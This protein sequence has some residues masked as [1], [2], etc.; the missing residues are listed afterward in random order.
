MERD[1]CRSGFRSFCMWGRVRTYLLTFVALLYVAGLPGS[2]ARGVL[3][4]LS[5]PALPKGL[6][7]RDGVL[8]VF[9]KDATKDDR[10]PIARARVHAFAILDGRAHGAARVTTGD[11]GH[12]KLERLPSAEHW[13]VA[14]A[15]GFAR[16]SQMVVVVAGAR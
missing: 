7:G 15:P 10:P 14:E 11:D 6:E 9:V 1:G 3:V 12:A 16:A 4:E 5:A 2:V 13:I 8:D